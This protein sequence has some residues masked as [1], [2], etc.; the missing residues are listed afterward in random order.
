MTKN[1]LNY[2]DLSDYDTRLHKEYKYVA[3]WEKMKEK[4]NFT[5]QTPIMTMAKSMSQ[6]DWVTLHNAVKYRRFSQERKKQH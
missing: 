5:D 4:Y 2:P 1:D 6:N 3:I